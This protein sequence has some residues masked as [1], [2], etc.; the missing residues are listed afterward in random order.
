MIN[1]AEK[2]ADIVSKGST[3]Y[4]LLDF[5]EFQKLE[6]IGPYTFIRPD[7]NARGKKQ[8]EELW[9]NYDIKY[10]E[11][12]NGWE[13]QNKVP[14]K[15]QINLD[16]C[17]ALI[18]IHDFKNIGVFFE[19][20]ENWNLLKK[21][22]ETEDSSKTTRF[23]N[24]FGYTGIAS[25]AACQSNAETTH[26]DSSKPACAWMKENLEINRI[27]T[28]CRVINEDCTTFVEKETKRGNKYNIIFADPPAFGRSDKGV[29]KLSKD[30]PEFMNKLGNIIAD[31]F[32][33]ILV[34]IYA[35]DMDYNVAVKEIAENL[36][37]LNG[38]LT[39]GNILQRSSFGKV[40]VSGFYI[41]ITP[42]EV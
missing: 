31:D 21:A 17:K 28:G 13:F 6:K 35:K 39:C 11:D 37:S 18:K 4:E 5:G 38:N 41:K 27:N 22:V 1:I 29:W 2:K 34:N 42:V 16:I 12:I 26:V 14:E 33:L 9:T 23:I 8:K 7:V 24:L 25:I 15:F 36:N 20:S 30:L 3:G 10:S 19:Q 32:K 40:L